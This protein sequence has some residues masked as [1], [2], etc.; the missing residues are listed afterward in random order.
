MQQTQTDPNDHK[1]NVTGDSTS[2]DSQNGYS[3][4]G[5]NI[6]TWTSN[7]LATAVVIIIALAVGTQLVSSFRP[8]EA[9]PESEIGKLANAWPALESCALEFGDSPVQ[10]HRESII[11]DRKQAVEALVNRCRLAL[12][13]KALPLNSEASNDPIGQTQN[14]DSNNQSQNDLVAKIVNSTVAPPIEEK[15]GEWRIF[16]VETTDSHQH[17]PLV[18]G[19]RD[20]LDSKS[21]RRNSD[22]RKTQTQM[23]VWG[24]AMPVNSKIKSDTTTTTAEPTESKANSKS[25]NASTSDDS[26][27]QWTTFVARRVPDGAAERQKAKLIPEG[28]KRTLAIAEPNGGS[29]I[30]FQCANVQS[31]IDYYNQLATSSSWKTTQPWRQKADSWSAQFKLPSESEIQGIQVQLSVNHNEKVRGMLLVK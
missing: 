7:L 21:D 2:R 30:G 23:V 17:L 3:N 25:K 24:L 20:N 4:V 8:D 29:L 14:S 10:L 6:T 28:A 5:R 15:K 12:E 16:H 9:S 27:A 1:S 11:G 13:Q 26:I 18:V 19:V 31:A 22:S